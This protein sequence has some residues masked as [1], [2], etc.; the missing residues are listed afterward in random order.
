MP[1]MLIMV[2]VLILAFPLL[3]PI[4]ATAGDCVVLLHGLARGPASLAAM[5]L[6]LKTEGYRTVNV[7][8]P[9]TETTIEASSNAALPDAIATC[10]PARRVHFVTHSMGGILVRAYLRGHRVANLGRIVMLAPPNHGSEIVDVLG[11]YRLFGWMSGPAGLELGHT[12]A[13]LP[14]RLGPVSYEVGII[15]GRRSISPLGSYLIDGAD[16]G[17]VSV[18]STHLEGMQ[19]HIVLPTTHTFM[20]L[21]P[22]VIAQTLTFLN[23]GSF[24]RDLTLKDFVIDRLP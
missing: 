23:T 1:H 5:E 12:P 19:D 10:G 8:Y 15:A 17:K 9:S 21:N 16:D 20:T 2:R 11:D 4:P 18:Q 14:D 24:D 6:A 13:G 3:A 7:D 22:Y